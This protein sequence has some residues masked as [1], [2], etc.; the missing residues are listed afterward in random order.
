MLTGSLGM[1]PSATLGAADSPG[2][3]R[4]PLRAD[5]RQR[6]GH[7]RPRLANPLAQILSLAMLLRYSFGMED[8]AALI[9]HAVETVLRQGRPH[10]RH[11]RPRPRPAFHHADGRCAAGRARRAI[12]LAPALAVRCRFGYT[13]PHGAP[14]AQLD[15]APDYESGGWEFELPSGAPTFFL[16]TNGLRPFTHGV[17]GRFFLASHAIP[18]NCNRRAVSRATRPPAPARRCA[19]RAHDGH[20][21]PQVQVERLGDKSARRPRSGCRTGPKPCNPV[22]HRDDMSG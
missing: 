8:N 2:P 10:R 16:Q 7:R 20:A 21:D 15:R 3:P 9:E 5:P 14:V 4:R 11:R 1:L 19:S 13:P 22:R 6:A 17:D 18:T 12:I